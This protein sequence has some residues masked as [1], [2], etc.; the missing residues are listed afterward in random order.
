MRLRL[1]PGVRMN[2]RSIC[3]AEWPAVDERVDQRFAHLVVVGADTRADRGN[4]TSAGL[5]PNW[6]CIDRDRRR[7][8]AARRCRAIRHGSPRRR[9]APDRQSGSARS[10]PPSPP[11]RARAGSTTIASPSGRS[12]ARVVGHRRRAASTRTDI[13]VDLLDAHQAIGRRAERRESPAASCRHLGNAS[14]RDVNKCCAARIEGA[15]L[16]ARRPQGSRRP[17]KCGVRLRRRHRRRARRG[18]NRGCRF[19]RD[20]RRTDRRFSPGLL[21]GITFDHRSVSDDTTRRDT[22]TRCREPAD[23][24]DN[25]VTVKI[26]PNEKGAPNGKL[27]DAELHFTAGAM[28]GLRLLGFSVWNQRN[29]PGRNVTFPARTYSVNGERR[30]F[31]LLRPVERL[32]IRRIAFATWSCRPTRNS[33][34]RRPSPAER[35]EHGACCRAGDAEGGSVEHRQQARVL[36]RPLRRRWLSC[37]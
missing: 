34:R 2:Q 4:Q 36:F 23:W 10:R 15:A 33:R 13:A 28:E 1:H 11:A 25:M 12:S 20:S 17:M 35:R 3:C 14:C 22:K 29:G 32:R 8:H 9:R 31:S 26:M 16:A 6:R 5:V 19:A 27:A 30:S 21:A 7:R 37:R 18:G 24:R